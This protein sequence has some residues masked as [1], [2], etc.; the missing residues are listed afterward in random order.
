M[1]G[2]IGSRVSNNRS[3][4]TAQLA[5]AFK[6]Y[7]ADGINSDGEALDGLVEENILGGSY[8]LSSAGQAARTKIIAA[9]R[10][11]KAIVPTVTGLA[12]SPTGRF[13]TTYTATVHGDARTTYSLT[14]SGANL[15]TRSVTTSSAG[16][17]AFN[18]LVPG[19]SKTGNFTITV[20]GTV[21]SRMD[22]YAAVDQPASQSQTVVTWGSGPGSSTA[23]GSVEPLIKVSITKLTA[24]DATKT[25]RAATF[26][27]VNK[28]TGVL[29]TNSFTTLS[30]RPTPLTGFTP[31]DTYAFAETKA[32]AGAYIP[33]QGTFTV[34]IPCTGADGFAIVLTDPRIPV[35][36]IATTANYQQTP[37]NTR[38]VDKVA[39]TGD[40]GE[41][42]TITG[43]LKRLAGVRCAAATAAQWA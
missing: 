38:L 2:L 8:V 11:Y 21:Y 16:T 7:G 39:L 4:T 6:V 34:T 29:L 13:N 23:R 19:T 15:S 41:A 20:A 37:Y 24:G 5:Y 28:T 9:A 35:I 25:P 14:V 18:Y 3:L 36:T 10:A 1:Y 30:G 40:D 33:S 32:P 43:S 42:G 31:C 27:V 12:T 26:R 17:A 22:E